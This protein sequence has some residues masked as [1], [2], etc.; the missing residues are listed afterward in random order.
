VPFEPAL[1]VEDE[2]GR[3]V[4]GPGLVGRRLTGADRGPVTETGNQEIAGDEEAGQ[5][6]EED[7]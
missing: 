7:C 1:E 6:D 2:S 3:I 5:R 4:L